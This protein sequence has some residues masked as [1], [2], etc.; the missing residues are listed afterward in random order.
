MNI[1]AIIAIPIR[2][3]FVVGALVVFALAIAWV[4][5]RWFYCAVTDTDF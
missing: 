1:P 3:V 2:A 5:V 4:C